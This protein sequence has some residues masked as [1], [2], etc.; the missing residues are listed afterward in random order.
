LTKI[1]WS[2]PSAIDSEPFWSSR[3]GQR[4]IQPLP[5][6]LAPLSLPSNFLSVIGHSGV[7]PGASPQ[8]QGANPHELANFGEG[9]AAF[10]QPS[11]DLGLGDLQQRREFRHRKQDG[12]MLSDTS[13]LL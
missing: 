1:R 2:F 11:A 5:L 4:A 10:E 6:R 9:Y 12:L 3:A 13:V 7:S 8:R